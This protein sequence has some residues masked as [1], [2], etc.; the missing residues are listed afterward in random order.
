MPPKKGGKVSERNNQERIR[1]ENRAITPRVAVVVPLDMMR[2]PLVTAAQGCLLLLGMLLN[3]LE[4]TDWPRWCHPFSVRGGLSSVIL[5]LLVCSSRST[6]SVTASRSLSTCS[7]VLRAFA[8]SDW[9]SVDYSTHVVSVSP[10]LYHTVLFRC[11]PRN[12][13]RV[14]MVT[15]LHDIYAPCTC[16]DVCA[17]LRKRVSI[18]PIR[19][20]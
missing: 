6:R 9:R 15:K 20:A 8:E 7:P 13:T 5:L 10:I 2:A 3:T 11:S 1:D 19:T 14:L 17:N 12:T 18:R 16:G 4:R